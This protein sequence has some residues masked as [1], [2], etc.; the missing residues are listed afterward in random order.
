MRFVYGFLPE[1]SLE[2]MVMAQAKKVALKRLKT[3]NATMRLEKQGLSNEEQKKAMDDMI[4]RISIE[5]PKDFW[6]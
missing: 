5:Q 3:L 4:A 1:G 2:E 6:D